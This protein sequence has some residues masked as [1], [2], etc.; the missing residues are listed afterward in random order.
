MLRA[1]VYAR[2]A[3]YRKPFLLDLGIIPRGMMG[4]I[5]GGMYR[6]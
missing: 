5:R 3:R 1:S 2:Y 6:P 4:R